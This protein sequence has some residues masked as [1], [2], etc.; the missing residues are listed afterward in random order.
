[1]MPTS[2]DNELLIRLADGRILQYDYY[3]NQVVAEV[4]AGNSSS[5]ST[6]P[7]FVALDDG[8]FLT[9]VGSRLLRLQYDQQ[10]FKSTMM[11]KLDTDTDPW[12]NMAFDA[13]NGLLILRTASKTF[14]VYKLQ[15]QSRSFKL[16]Q[17]VYLSELPSDISTMLA[18]ERESH[19]YLGLQNGMIGMVDLNTESGVLIRDSWKAFSQGSHE[20]RVISLQEDQENHRLFSSG[21]DGRI[22]VF[23][24]NMQNNTYQ[25]EYEIQDIQPVHQMLYLDDQLISI[26]SSFTFSN[27]SSNGR[28]GFW[29]LDLRPMA[30]KLRAFYKTQGISLSSQ[31]NI[32]MK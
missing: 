29:P 17:E 25:Q 26:S 7:P 11:M 10:R 13:Q 8:S 6:H 27:D 1:M 22:F 12:V 28:L 18:Q 20:G 31:P 32:R 3:Y 30:E 23:K 5:L 16:S 9:L 21:M 19:L 4:D 2:R 15:P 24:M 14:Q